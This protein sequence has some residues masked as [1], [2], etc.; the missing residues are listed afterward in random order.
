MSVGW[1]IVICLVIL[2]GVACAAPGERACNK[3]RETIADRVQGNLNTFEFREEVKKVVE[4]AEGAE[5]EIKQAASKLLDAANTLSN[6]RLD[7]S[8]AI[9]MENCIRSGY[10]EPE[11]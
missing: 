4:K 9:M 1:L 10:L 3:F 2:A 5:R 6:A 7:V 11:R 8:I